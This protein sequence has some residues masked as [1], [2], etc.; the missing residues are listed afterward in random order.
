V[1]EKGP[2]QRSKV[3]WFFFSKKNIFLPQRSRV[4]LA[5]IPVPGSHTILHR[6]HSAEAVDQKQAASQQSEDDEDGSDL[7][8]GVFFG[9]RQSGFVQGRCKKRLVLSRV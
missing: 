2:R 6:A 5:T 9:I 4:A 3:F 1:V 7:A 8:A